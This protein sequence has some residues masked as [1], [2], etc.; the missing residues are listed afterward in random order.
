LQSSSTPE[1]YFANSISANKLRWNGWVAIVYF[2]ATL[3]VTLLSFLPEQAPLAVGAAFQIALAV[4]GIYLFLELFRFLQARFDC[5]GIGIYVL[6]YIGL[7]VLMTIVSCIGAFQTTDEL[8]ITMTLM[9]G[10]LPVF[11]LFMFLFG[12]KLRRIGAPTRELRR[13]STV[14]LVSGGCAVSI[15]LIPAALILWFAWD[16]LLAQMFF[17]GAE[18][19]DAG[20]R[21]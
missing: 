15:V 9:L 6:S 8:T 3:L 16:V 12:L 7:T 14:T 19:L 5:E 18:E 2:V 20:R 10:S 4:I 13:F 21:T 1:S 17:A 11:G